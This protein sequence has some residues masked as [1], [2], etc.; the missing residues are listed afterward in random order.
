MFN[1]FWVYVDKP[2]L[3]IMTKCSCINSYLNLL[4]LIANYTSN[5][6]DWKR[7]ANRKK[8]II[9]SFFHTI[10]Q[11]LKPNR[12]DINNVGNLKYFLLILTKFDMFI[13]F[14]SICCSRSSS[15]YPC[16]LLTRKIVHIYLKI[17]KNII[18][19]NVKL[20]SGWIF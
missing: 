2:I 12:V 17:L 8:M 7:I 11:V 19:S 18:C 14:F 5:H 6:A 10:K 20:N 4:P 15:F 13:S 16:L 9:T 3:Q 1:E